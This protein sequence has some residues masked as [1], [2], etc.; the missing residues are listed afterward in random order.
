MYARGGDANA[1]SR[2]G[3]PGSATALGTQSRK[4]SGYVV[5]PGS[6]QGPGNGESMVVYSMEAA[7]VGGYGLAN[8]A[9]YAALSPGGFGGT[10]FAKLYGSVKATPWWKITFQGLYIGDT[11]KHG[12]TLG[13]AFKFPVGGQLQNDASIGWEFDLI[14]EF[15]IYSN[16]R[17][18]VGFG[19]LF[20]GDALDV[21][22][23]LAG[24]NYN[25]SIAD[26]WALRTRLQYT[27]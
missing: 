3:L 8:R 16:L 7:A 17:W 11:T 20:A 4:F 21:G 9:N 26:P 10:W 25:K 2:T 13:N 12:N 6:E 24:V 14:N 15:Q 22:K 5:P 1:S 18:F 19:Y 23:T 27:F